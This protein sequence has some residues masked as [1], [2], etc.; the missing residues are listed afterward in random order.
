MFAS[1]NKLEIGE[2]KVEAAGFG[3]PE[4]DRFVAR[5]HLSPGKP[6]LR[7][8][9]G[10]TYQAAETALLERLDVVATREVSCI[11]CADTGSLRYGPGREMDCPHCEEVSK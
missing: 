11:H 8:A 9:Y 5:V 2:I 6:G 4:S 10:P 7:F 3:V 1:G